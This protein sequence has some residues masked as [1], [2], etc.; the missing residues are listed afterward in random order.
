MKSSQ[1]VVS[2]RTLQNQ[3]LLQLLF[4]LRRRQRKRW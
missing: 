3:L 2:Y 4:Q 1:I